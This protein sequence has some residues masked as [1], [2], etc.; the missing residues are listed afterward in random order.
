MTQ[1]LW[2]LGAGTLTTAA[3]AA[4]S[5]TL[6]TGWTGAT[7]SCPWLVAADYLVTP[8]VERETTLS[9][10]DK[11]QG[12][13]N[14]TWR[15]AKLNDAMFD[16]LVNTVFGGAYTAV[17]TVKTRNRFFDDVV[18]NQW[19]TINCK[20]RLPDFRLGGVNARQWTFYSPFQI[21]FFDGTYAAAS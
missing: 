8:Y 19:V 16:Y 14:F 10:F 3:L 2:R 18:A 6:V 7:A 13:L 11:A 15:F 17:V 1:R 12:K 5:A 9:N 4:D 21:E 20:A